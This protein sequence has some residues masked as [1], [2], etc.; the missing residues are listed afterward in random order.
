MAFLTGLR[1]GGYPT[2]TPSVAELFISACLL[3]TLFTFALLRSGRVST[4]DLAERTDRILPSAFTAVCCLV[5][6]AVLHVTAAPSSVSDLA[7]GVSSQMTLLAALTTRWKVSYHSASVTALLVVG[8]SLDN[9]VLTL[10]LLAF[11]FCVGWARV[12]Q[13]RHT[14]AQVA[15]GAL[16]TVPLAFLT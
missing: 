12:Y 14:L 15:V 10:A 8:R 5:G 16:T 4:L 13:R 11:A 9:P 7:I 2:S 6:W 3:P 1:G